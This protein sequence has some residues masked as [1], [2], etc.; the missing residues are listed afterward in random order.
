MQVLITTVGKERRRF[1][2]KSLLSSYG[3][4]PKFH[5][6]LS[7]L[8]IPRPLARVHGSVVTAVKLFDT[9]QQAFKS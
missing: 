4:L 1:E 6:A 5:T 2:A 8:H 7:L 9:R 3:S